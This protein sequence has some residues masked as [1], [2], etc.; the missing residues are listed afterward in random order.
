M[1]IDL[2]NRQLRMRWTNGTENRI[3]HRVVAAEGDWSIVSCDNLANGCLDQRTRFASG[4]KS[5]VSLV[6]E[7]V[8]LDQLESRFTPR[9]GRRRVKCRANERRCRGSAAAERR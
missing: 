7:R 2:K 4:R 8:A 6:G 5:D 1:R 3:G 9:V